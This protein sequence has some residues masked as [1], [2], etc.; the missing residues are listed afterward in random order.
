MTDI[1]KLVK[2]A[3][4]RLGEAYA[5]HSNYHVGAAVLT[6]SGEVYTGVNIENDNYTNTRHAEETAIMKAVDDGHREITHLAV[7]TQDNSNESDDVRGR[8]SP[9]P[10]G[11]CKQT[12]TQFIDGSIEVALGHT[13]GFRVVEL[14]EEFQL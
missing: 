5:P 7:V 6:K 4:S 9:E 2:Q 14:T 1:E 8:E 3:E 10:C 12:I 13:E 11:S